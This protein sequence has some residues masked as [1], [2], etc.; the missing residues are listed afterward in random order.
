MTPWFIATRPFT[1][2]EGERWNDFLVR[3]VRGVE[4]KNVLCVFRNPV[5]RPVA[6][7]VADFEFPGYDL[8]DVENNNSALTNCGGFPDVFAKSEL[9]RVG[10]VPELGRAI[11]VQRRLR[12]LYPEEHHA[13]CHVWGIFR[14]VGL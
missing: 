1:P 6:P 10:L 13:N 9:S 5:E 2:G 4:R 3:Q 12:S 8:V 11:E 7:S 14:A